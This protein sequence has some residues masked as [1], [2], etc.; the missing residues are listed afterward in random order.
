MTRLGLRRSTGLL[1]LFGLLSRIKLARGADLASAARIQYM[2]PL[3]GAILGA[4]VAVVSFLIFEVI[5]DA[6]SSLTIALVAVLVLYF[7]YGIMHLEGLADFGDGV[8]ASGDTL[9]KRSAMKDVSVGAA[10][11]FFM[12]VDLLLLVLLINELL[13]QTGPMLLVGIQIPLIFGLIVA[14]ISA[15]LSMMTVM[16]IGP[17]SHEGMGSVFTSQSSIKR[18]AAG[19]SISLL[20]SLLFIGIYFPIVLAGVLSGAFVAYLSR[21]HFGGVGGD[22]FG[23]ANELGRLV[24]LFIW[25]L[26]I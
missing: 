7:I 14:E 3:V 21:R 16:F 11:C 4:I 19:L 6:I 26:V 12:V 15:K 20:L 25:V 2:F 8:M 10:G 13:G 22:S 23:A 9:K 17:S 18:F 1:Q 5:G 24:T